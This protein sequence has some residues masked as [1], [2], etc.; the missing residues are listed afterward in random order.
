ML[1][2]LH[3]YPKNT[4]IFF[5][6]YRINSKTQTRLKPNSSKI[7][8]F[9]IN[10]YYNLHFSTTPH[11]QFFP[12][13]PGTYFFTKF[14]STFNFIEVL[15]DDKP[16]TCATIIQNSTNHI[17][18]LPIG[19]FGFIEIP[20]TNEKPKCY[21]INDM[22]TL[23]HNVTYTYH[24]ELTEPIPPTNYSK[25]PEKQSTSSIPFSLHQVYMTSPNPL[26]RTPSL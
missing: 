25:P 14:R 3:Y 26:P 23:I 9:P 1:R 20:I 2:L 17:A 22:N 5:Y 4:H 13:I 18:T 6:I 19:H 11:K 10:N 21:R 15:T 24:P 8:H 12:T 16:D 7:A